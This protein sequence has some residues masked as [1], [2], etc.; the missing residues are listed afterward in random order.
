MKTA[1]RLS[2]LHTYGVRSLKLLHTETRHESE[3]K[4]SSLSLSYL[5]TLYHP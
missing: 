5:A 4:T 3:G 1:I 2:Q